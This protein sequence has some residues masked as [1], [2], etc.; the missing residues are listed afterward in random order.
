MGSGLVQVLTKVPHTYKLG[1]A[2]LIGGGAVTVYG[3]A[4]QSPN[5]EDMET[6]QIPWVQ[7]LANKEGMREVLVPGQ[8]LRKHPIGQ[9]ISED[10]HMVG[11]CSPLQPYDLARTA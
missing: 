10:D 11:A 3:T 2:A 7:E 8:M 4:Q 6:S 1:T 9:L 5:A